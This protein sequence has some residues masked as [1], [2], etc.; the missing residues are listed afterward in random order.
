MKARIAGIKTESVTDGPGVRSLVFFQGCPHHC[1]GCHN[2]HTWAVDAGDELDLDDL[3]AQLKVSPLIMG[4]TLSGGEPFFQPQASTWIAKKFHNT[5]KN[6]WVYT[7]YVWEDL[8]NNI[9]PAIHNL[10]HECDVIVDGP[11]IQSLRNIDLLFRGSD[12]QRII[13]VQQSLIKGE[14]MNWVEI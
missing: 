4:V 14:L 13:D 8:V 1:Q 2:P 11:F 5:G 6:V 10:L 7:G 12:N 9:D 3:W